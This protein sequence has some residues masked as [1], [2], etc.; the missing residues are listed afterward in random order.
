MNLF[1]FAAG[2]ALNR[3]V[4]GSRLYCLLLNGKAP[5]RLR[6]TPPNPWPGDAEAAK[7]FLEPPSVLPGITKPGDDRP[8][9][10]LPENNPKVA[11][12]HRFA[13]LADFH[14]LGTEPAR[15]RSQTL[16]EAW[17]T[18]QDDWHPLSWRPDILGERLCHWFV[19]Y[20]FLSAGM[21]DTDRAILLESMARQARHLKRL[22]GGPPRD[23]R[24]LLVLKGTIYCGVCLPGF[25]ALLDNG[26]ARLERAIDRQI[27][28]DG[29][30]IGRNP[31]V[32]LD[33]LRHLI[34]IRATLIAGQVEVPT[35]LQSG[36]D[37]MGPM[38][39]TLRHVDGGFALFQGGITGDNDSINQVL[40][41]A[42]TRARAL[43]NAPHT[44]YQRLTAGRTVILA[45]TGGPPPPGFDRSAHASPLGFELSVG[46]ERLIVNCGAFTGADPAWRQAL[47]ATAAHSTLTLNDT[48]AF[49]ITPQGRRPRKNLHVEAARREADGNI[50]L[51]ASHDGY[52]RAFGLVHKRRLYLATGGDDIRG[53]DELAGTAETG[54]FAIR[55]HLHPDVRASLVQDGSAVLMRLKSGAGWQFRANGG[56]LGIEPSIYLGDGMTTRHTR[57]IVLTGDIKNDGTLVKW[58]LNRV[59]A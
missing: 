47:R 27:L 44:G 42:G 36:I 45:D 57:Q 26:L 16:L 34:D 38:L 56:V 13:W 50:W 59:K 49:E 55:F 40:I 52:R 5:D 9:Q 2:T 41:Q 32:M 24:L 48:N 33:L 6:G 25:E 8:W 19:H 39:R 10:L 15:T 12:W 28:P 46:K 17:L 14:A 58:R 54:T 53:D 37:R 7:P 4:F 1:S 3:F 11:F 23:A 51:E 18:D 22:A 30:H 29:G 21:I 31:S 20:E 35:F 43:S